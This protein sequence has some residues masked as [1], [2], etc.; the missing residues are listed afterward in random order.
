MSEE[1]QTIAPD[2]AVLEQITRAEIDMKVATAKKY[3]RTLSR[4]RERVLE[5]STLDDET[6]AQCFYS[7]PRGGKSITGE[8]VRL[9]EILASCYGNIIAGARI[10]SID[11]REGVVTTQGVCHDLENNVS[12]TIEK[13][14]Q[15]QRK[16]SQKESDPYDEDMITLAANA[17]AAIAYRDAVFKVI[18]KAIVRPI[19]RQIKDAARG[20]G[21]LPEK[22]DRVVNRLVEM[23]IKEGRVLAA[24]DCR[25]REDVGLDKLDT[26]IGLGTA[27]RDGEISKEDAFPAADPNSKSAAFAPAKEAEKAEEATEGEE[28]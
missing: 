23:G 11:H 8:S 14:R 21:T 3:P 25:K 12:T 27:I 2:N 6:A 15:I 16:R 4:V 17:G 7:L 5:L 18:P 9:A 22:V 20:K 13:R 28:A 19:L 24:V 1:T 26:L 10:V